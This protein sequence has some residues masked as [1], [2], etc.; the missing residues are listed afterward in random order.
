MK[1]LLWGI[2]VE[3][4]LREAHGLHFVQL[5]THPHQTEAQQSWM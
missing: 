2:S 1:D 5:C 4:E 3:A